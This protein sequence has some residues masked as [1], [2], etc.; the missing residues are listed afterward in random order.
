MSSVSISEALSRVRAPSV[1]EM[2][3][4]G[5]CPEEL[6]TDRNAK[7][8][9]WILPSRKTRWDLQHAQL[10]GAKGEAEIVAWKQSSSSGPRVS[11]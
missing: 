9:P 6:D 4:R 3:F 7:E 11:E 10:Q 8:E 5:R 2:D 1:H